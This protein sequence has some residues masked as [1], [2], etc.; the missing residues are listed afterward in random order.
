MSKFPPLNPKNPMFEH[1]ALQATN[2]LEKA[3]DDEIERLDNLNT[4]DLATIRAKRI[5][6]MKAQAEKAAQNE[7]V[8]HGTLRE[9]AN[10]KEFFAEVK[11]SDRVV[12]H[13]FRP[14]SK[15]CDILN[16]HLTVIAQRHKETRFLTINAEKS[17]FLAERLNIWMLP[18]L[19]YCQNGKTNMGMVGLDAVGSNL[20]FKTGHLENVLAMGK[21]IDI[22]HEVDFDDDSD[23]FK[24]EDDFAGSDSDF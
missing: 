11:K 3:V 14:A 24:D 21:M 20:N 19:V 16:Q 10:E 12:V 9:L 8:G 6:E 13:F 15:P 22:D 7:R 23:D 17:P 5:A 18:T 1:V 4:D 2:V